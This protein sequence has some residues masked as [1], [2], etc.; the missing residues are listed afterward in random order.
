MKRKKI[1]RRNPMARAMLERRQSP[2]VIPPKKGSKATH[3]RQKGNQ[4]AI[5]DQELSKDS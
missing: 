3:N 4:D 1:I 5:R 2:Q